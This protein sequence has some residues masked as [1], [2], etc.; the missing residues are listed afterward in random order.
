MVCMFTGHRDIRFEDVNTLPVWLDER[1]EEYIALGYTDFCVGG[2]TGFDTL[3]EL[4]ILEKKKKYGFI[5]LHLYLP[6]RDQDKS[7]T[8]NQKAMYR[9]VL[10]HADSIN[11]VS[12]NYFRGC[13]HKRNREMVEA[14]DVCIA[15]CH[16]QKG[17]SRYT[18]TH[19]QKKGVKVVNFFD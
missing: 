3:A 11:Y 6:C 2:A 14:S 8:D 17:G 4:K 18:V 16:S 7:W 9:V 19:C 1:I 5:K 13:M 10:E 15:Y 12:E